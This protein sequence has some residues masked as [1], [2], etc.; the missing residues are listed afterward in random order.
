MV[1]LLFSLESICL[2]FIRYI[3]SEYI[4]LWSPHFQFSTGTEIPKQTKKADGTMKAM[5]IEHEE[6][7][8]QAMIQPYVGG[9]L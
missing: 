3:Y 7:L 9:W 4:S 1:Q 8:R 5:G 6:N 2:V